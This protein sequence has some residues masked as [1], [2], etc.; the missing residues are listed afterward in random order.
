MNKKYLAITLVVI[1]V[2]AGA[3]GYLAYN[4]T[5]SPK[6][7]TLI[8]FAASSMTNVIAN[9][10]QAFETA[11]NCKI[12]VNSASSSTLETQIVAG[13]PCDV[14][15]SAN[16]KWTIALD[17]AGLLYQNYYNNFTKNSLCIIVAAGNPKN[18]TSLAD[19]VKPGVRLIVADASVPVGE[20][21]NDTVYNIAATWGNASSPLYVTSGAYLNYPAKFAANVVSYED[22]DENIV[23]DVSLNVGTADAGIV[24]YSDWAYG[25]LTHAQVSYLPIPD[26]VNHIGIYGICI[27]SESTQ[28]AL[29]QKFENYWLSPQG[30]ALLTEFGFGT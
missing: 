22:T 23:G 27:P 9:M 10:T 1:I 16:N 2:V 25:N 12:V 6:K 4:G 14:F 29:S 30:Q 18:I 20:Y 5:F 24:F 28:I 3:L 8:V 11:N 21:T 7:T 13:S 19:L 15:M 17:S 26:V